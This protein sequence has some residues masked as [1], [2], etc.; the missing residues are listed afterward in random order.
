MLSYRWRE[1]L[2]P[3]WLI[4]P[5]AVLVFVIILYP[6]AF[7]VEISLR[8]VGIRELG[9][10]GQARWLGLENY[11]KQLQNQ[12]FWD[13]MGRTAYLTVSYR[14]LTPLETP[15]TM[16]TWVEISEIQFFL[17]RGRIFQA[18]ELSRNFCWQSGFL[19]RERNAS[20]ESR[21]NL[22]KSLRQTVLKP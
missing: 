20:A 2:F 9:D 6:L 5:T 3:Y 1:R 11:V 19:L 8:D 7:S 18:N 16:K 4:L 22:R 12:Q 21:M 14:S 10:P 17:K 15:L 13:I